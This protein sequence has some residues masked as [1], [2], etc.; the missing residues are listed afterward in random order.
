M[1]MIVVSG[2][3]Q[4]KKLLGA[5]PDLNTRPAIAIRYF[6]KTEGRVAL[7]PRFFHRRATCRFHK[8]LADGYPRGR[9]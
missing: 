6:S 8:R 1:T 4:T 5:I 7:H 9:Q 2:G 3:G